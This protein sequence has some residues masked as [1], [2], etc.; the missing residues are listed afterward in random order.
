MLTVDKITNN[1]LTYRL[2][3]PYSQS[4]VSF[5]FSGADAENVYFAMNKDVYS[6]Y[7]D[8]DISLV[9]FLGRKLQNFWNILFNQ[10]PLID[11]KARIVE[12]S[13]KKHA[14]EVLELDEEA[15]AGLTADTDLTELGLD[16]MTCVEVVVNLEDEF[17][18]T[19]E[20]EDLAVE[21]MAT[22]GKLIE[23]IEKYNA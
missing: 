9:Q 1:N 21:N 4:K 6:N 15:A 8:G 22:I 10:D 7:V 18:V 13:L 5:G 11:L 16:S 12:E 17:G 14:D 2:N 3:M 23:L 20:E 19:V